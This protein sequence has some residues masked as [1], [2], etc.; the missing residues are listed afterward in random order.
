MGY[1]GFGGNNINRPTNNIGVKG[2]MEHC[3][4]VRRWVE[5]G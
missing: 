3:L 4:R 5:V 1:E 2:S